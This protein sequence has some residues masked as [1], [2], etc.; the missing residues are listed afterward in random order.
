MI[1]SRRLRHSLR[2]F[3]SFSNLSTSEMYSYAFY[4]Y[5]AAKVDKDMS[6]NFDFY[7]TIIS[8]AKKLGKTEELSFV[9]SECVY[10]LEK[11]NYLQIASDD[12]IKDPSNRIDRLKAYLGK[13]TNSSNRI[14]EIKYTIDVDFYGRNCLSLSRIELNQE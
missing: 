8:L 2:L 10:E 1:R 13:E 7:E 9:L 11:N 3:K 4:L 6:L 5:T 14:Q 12:F